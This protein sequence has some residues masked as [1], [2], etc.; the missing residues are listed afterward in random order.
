MTDDEDPA[1]PRAAA[2]DLEDWLTDLRT[3]E[4]DAPA[5]VETEVEAERP[6]TVGRHRAPE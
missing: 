6:S 1:A 3:E 2:D 4:A 5:W